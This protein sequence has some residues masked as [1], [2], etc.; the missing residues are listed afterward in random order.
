MNS[1]KTDLKLIILEAVYCSGQGVTL[2]H[3]KKKLSESST[4]FTLPTVLNCIVE[5][6]V[7][8]P[9][10]KEV[11]ND[12]T[13][14]IWDKNKEKAN[15]W[16]KIAKLSQLI[17]PYE[18]KYKNGLANAE[19]IQKNEKIMTIS[20]IIENYIAVNTSGQIHSAKCPFCD[21]VKNSLKINDKKNMFKCFGCGA[22]GD[23]IFFVKA[24]TKR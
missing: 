23:A 16:V 12:T 2:D 14:W 18:N 20:K 17:F 5:L 9:V 19:L 6:C 21:D 13:Y 15:S 7:L 1:Y 24:F 11:R 3:I 10:A 4:S 22:G 8:T